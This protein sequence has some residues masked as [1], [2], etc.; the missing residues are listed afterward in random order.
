VSAQSR[1][2]T[3]G[4]RATLAD[5]LAYWLLSMRL[6]ALQWRARRQ[7]RRGECSTVASLIAAG[8][9]AKLDQLCD[10]WVAE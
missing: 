5:Y 10:G 3:T 4:A 7:V 6:A 2:D 1:T 9:W 8:D